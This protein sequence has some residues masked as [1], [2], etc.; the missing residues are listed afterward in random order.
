MRRRGRRREG[1][2]RAS[3]S[4][5]PSRRR[6]EGK[7]REG[8]ARTASVEGRKGR[9]CS[10]QLEEGEESGA[11]LVSGATPRREGEL[12]SRE[13]S[14]RLSMKRSETRPWPTGGGKGKRRG[15][16]EK[17][18]GGQEPG[19]RRAGRKA[20]RAGATRRARNGRRQARSRVGGLGKKGASCDACPAVARTAGEHV[21]HERANR[22]QTCFPQPKARYRYRPR[23]SSN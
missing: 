7:K 23:L 2:R 15:I 5:Q 4:D 3:S 21:G 17:E 14:S 12:E 16:G 11:G 20:R 13:Q 18:D 22:A 10:R 9:R 8:S 6:V 1:W 19:K